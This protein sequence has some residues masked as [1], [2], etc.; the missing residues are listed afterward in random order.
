M[1]PLFQARRVYS[2]SWSIGFWKNY[3]FKC[4]WWTRQTRQRKSNHQ[5]Y[6]H[7]STKF[8]QINR[9]QVKKHWFCVSGIQLI[10]VLTAKE[11]VE[12]ITFMQGDSASERKA[13]SEELLNVVGLSTSNRRPGQLSGGNNKE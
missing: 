6:R 8:K 10:P 9:F 2:N 13:R 11:N 1:C 7:Y 12:F 3:F 4:H 5:Q